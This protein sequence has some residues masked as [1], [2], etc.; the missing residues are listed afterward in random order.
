MR[1]SNRVILGLSIAM[2]AG[3]GPGSGEADAQQTP[4]QL[5]PSPLLTG[6]SQT[7]PTTLYAPSSSQRAAK[8]PPATRPAS[9]A[10]A[11][12][13]SSVYDRVTGPRTLTDALASAY[14]TNPALQAARAT[15][16]ATDE[17]VPQAL[18]GWRPTVTVGGNAG[19]GNGTAR[20]AGISQPQNTPRQLG[21]AT[22]TVSQP[23]YEGGRTRANT[24]QA[25]NQV[26]SQRATLL[27]QEQ[28]TFVN[29]VQYYVD[30]IRQ[31]QTLELRINNERVLAKQ[32]QATNDRF[33]VGEITRTDVAQAQAALAQ[34]TADRQA[35]EGTLATVRASFLQYVGYQPPSDLIEPQPL[36]LPVK[37]RADAIALA[38]TN[39]PNVVA[40]M[41][42]DAAA[43]DFVDVEISKLLPTLSLQGEAFDQTNQTLR[44]TNSKGYQVLANLSVP[45]YQGGSEY[46]AV[47]QARQT[48]QANRKRLDDARRTAIQQASQSWD[49]VIAA[50][51]TAE[52]T[53]AQIRANAIALEGV[54]R[55]AIVGS[56]TTL[57]VLNAQQALL[58]SQ[59]TLVNNLADLV[60]ASYNLAAAIGRLTA[61]DLNL[62]VARYDFTAYYNAVR[63]RWIGLGDYATDQPGR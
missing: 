21:Q 20:T 63:N 51:A 17:N 56:R 54:E 7:R 4:G 36:A 24:N 2:A 58:N 34:A 9:N 19:Y 61:E 32:L 1:L 37:T 27:A 5:L 50:R 28:S 25:E 31:K 6:Q 14:A 35:T 47:R 26:L 3:P 53:R 22:A 10:T 48:E 46:A 40:A 16:R 8:A 12:E 33:R 18:A 13:R 45:L 39:N 43:R 41:F 42:N 49:T 57:D 52:S 15:L 11:V 38:A 55:E 30:V 59:V 23:L 60:T 62:P 44:G 29:V